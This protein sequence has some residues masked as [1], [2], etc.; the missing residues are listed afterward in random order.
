MAL[1]FLDSNLLLR[2]LLD[3]HPK[4]SPRAKAYIQ[5]IEQGRRQVRI[6]DIVI[7]ETVYTLQSRYHVPKAD[8]C[9]ALLP[10]INLPGMVLPG[11][12]RFR[13]VF[14]RYVALN[15]SFADAYHTVLMEQ[16]KLSEVVSFDRDFDRVTGINR[17]TL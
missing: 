16:L 5:S 3:D 14:E 9:D 17:V 2:H 11:K 4:F 13:K 8:I 15:I 10:L 12:R 7:F 6:S 1:P